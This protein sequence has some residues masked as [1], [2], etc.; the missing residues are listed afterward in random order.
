M[1]DFT[2]RHERERNPQRHEVTDGLWLRESRAGR[3]GLGAATMA[4]LGT[5]GFSTTHGEVLGV[6]VGWSGNSV[7]RVERDPATGTT[8]RRR[9]AAAP[10]EVR[11]AEGE[12]YS[13]PWV[14]V[15]AA[16]DGLDGLAAAW[17]A[18]QR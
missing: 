10:G 5:P 12:S 7:L 16:D 8:D 4:V 9:R 14:Y 6:H 13:T 18:H 11:L 1:L 3:P 17:H 2:G 15:A